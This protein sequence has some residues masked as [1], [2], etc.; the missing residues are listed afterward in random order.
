MK[1]KK[2]KKDAF[3]IIPQTKEAS[4]TILKLTSENQILTINVNKKHMNQILR[5]TTLIQ[6]STKTTNKGDKMKN[7]KTTNNKITE[8]IENIKNPPNLEN[9]P[10]RY[11]IHIARNE[12]NY[13]FAILECININESITVVNAIELHKNAH[14]PNRGIYPSWNEAAVA[15]LTVLKQLKPN[16]DIDVKIKTENQ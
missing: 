13:H 12:Y 15:A 5:E 16:A 4:N 6:E 11:E 9:L 8:A 14:I 2:E 10:K 7:E 3:L 1:D